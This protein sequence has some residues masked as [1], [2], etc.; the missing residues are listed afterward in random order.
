MKIS[1]QNTIPVIPLLPSFDKLIEVPK[2]HPLDISLIQTPKTITNVIQTPD[3][4]HEQLSRDR[5][6]HIINQI[7]HCMVIISGVEITRHCTQSI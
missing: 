2:T 4:G 6:L 3:W 7:L 1:Y 5:F